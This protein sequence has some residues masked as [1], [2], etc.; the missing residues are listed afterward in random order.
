VPLLDHQVIDAASRLDEEVLYQPLGKKKLLRTLVEQ[1]LPAGIFD[2]PKAGF[3]L[4]IEQWCRRSLG[5]TVEETLRDTDLKQ[6]L[7]LDSVAVSNLWQAYQEGAPGI[8]WSRVWSIF[9]LMDWCRKHG[10]RA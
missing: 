5:D 7:G 3:V 2:R 8:H 4:P 9:V 6:E 10:V 1:D